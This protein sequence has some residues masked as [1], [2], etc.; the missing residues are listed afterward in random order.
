MSKGGNW[1]DTIYGVMTKYLFMDNTRAAWSLTRHRHRFQRSPRPPAAARARLRRRT[2]YGRTAS[3]RAGWTPSMFNGRNPDLRLMTVVGNGN[4]ES[5]PG[6]SGGTRSGV[7]DRENVTRTFKIG[8]TIVCP[9][10]RRLD[11]IDETMR[12]LCLT[13]NKPSPADCGNRASASAT[14][15]GVRST[16]ALTENLVHT[17]TRRFPQFRTA[18]SGGPV[19]T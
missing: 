12:I 18:P 2:G 1:V 17:G 10:G 5:T 7:H 8:S 13:C 15:P 6:C 14:R 11:S 9:A 19:T 4:A 16:F 3:C